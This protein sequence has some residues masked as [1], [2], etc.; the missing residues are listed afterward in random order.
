M[1]SSGGLLHRSLLSLLLWTAVARGVDA[2][3][4]A[5]FGCPIP[6]PPP[7]TRLATDLKATDGRLSGVDGQEDSINII[8]GDM[9]VDLNGP[10]TFKDRLVLRQGNRQFAADGGRYDRNSGEFAVTGNVDFRDPV[11]WVRGNT[12]R[13]NSTTGR[14]SIEDAEYDLFT[15]PARGSADRIAVEAT[16]QLV[17][18]NVT[19]TSCARG[20]NDWLLHAGSL[21]VDRTAGTATV[22]N[23][24]LEFLGVPILYT[25]YLTYPIDNRRKSGL[26]L[27]DVGSSQQRGIEYAQPYYLN[28]APNYDATLTP[29]YMSRRGLQA[30]GEF[31]YLSGG[32]SG[33]VTG[34]FLPNDQVSGENRSQLAWFNRS[35]LPAGWRT[36]IDATDV[37]DTGYY[38]DLS[39]GLA[40]TS[41]VALTRR[42]DFERFSESWSALL[43]VQEYE[44]LDDAITPEEEPYREVP[45]LGINGY[46]PDAGFGMAL[47]VASEFTYF[48]R[49]T[50][51]TGSRAHLQPEASL[52]LEFG[53]LRIEPYVGLDYTAYDLKHVAPDA[54]D[55]P[56]RAVPI[57][58]IDVRTLLERAWGS[59]GEWLQ[60]IEP[61]AQFLYVPFDDQKEFPVF[62]T[63][64]PDFSLVQLFRR[65]RY[66]GL[67]RLGD[68]SQLNL[69]ITTRLMRSKDGSQFLT[70][71]VGETQYFSP[72]D[73]VLPGEL[74]SNDTASDYIAEL[75]MNLNDQWKMDLGYQWDS[76]QSVTQLAEARILYRGDD[77]R[78]LNASYRFRRDSV[79][80][81]DV[82]GAWPIGDRWN[83]VGRYDYSLLDNEPLERFVGLD[84][85]TCCWGVRLVA[86][87]NLSSREGESD[88]AI[89]LQLL[90]KGFGS[91]RSPAE[92]LLDRGILGYDSFDRY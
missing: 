92:S 52:P 15:V 4:P 25:P 17:L 34:A 65:N 33:S 70:A 61:R 45:R 74:P 46:W 50:G 8:S 9:E 41:R 57:Y 59:G 56:S 64:Q 67:D 7:I 31:R 81:I 58:S 21:N 6:A 62:D 44:L 85:S 86:R 29:H 47:G 49:G 37:S 60:T 12:A 43:R 79:R 88:S 55:S 28:L 90:L 32:T 26:L 48:D 24:R 87:R 16:E 42:V 23:A 72:Q 11:T 22:R 76:D 40:N 2:N 35:Q 20:N 75:G 68:S 54:D 36:T 39:S 53:P 38:E 66:V 82:A 77:F 13:Y 18:T 89:S 80:E 78:V 30:Q 14:F 27:P 51:V 73:V 1:T 10:A 63:I 5:V 19:Y 3:P 71:T 83:I 91:T 84:Y 69:G